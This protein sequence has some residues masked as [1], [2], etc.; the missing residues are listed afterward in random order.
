MPTGRR[1]SII[2]GI[3]VIA[4]VVTTMVYPRLPDRFASHWNASGK[5]DGW[6]QKG[7]GVFLLPLLMLGLVIL[8][9]VLPLVDPLKRNITS[10]RPYYDT[11][12]MIFL[13]FLL[14]I[15]MQILLWNLGKQISPNKFL[16]IP[17]GI[18]IYYAGVLMQHATP[19]WFVGVRTHWTLS[20]DRVWEQTHRVTGLLFR[21]CGVISV[22]GFAF[23]DLWLVLFMAPLLASTVFA[24]A[25]SYVLYR[26]ELLERS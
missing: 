21:V 23:P 4:F 3:V 6:M 5:A 20:S 17:M 13:V 2:A 15:Q 24:V 14:A 11:F 18:L 25:F 22:V 8:F 19:N 12:I 16:P 10:F 26:R 1:L 9:M 7:W